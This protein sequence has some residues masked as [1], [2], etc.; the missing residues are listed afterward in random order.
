MGADIKAVSN[1]IACVT[2]QTDLTADAVESTD[3]RASA[4]LVAAGLIAKGETV[5]SK[6]EH[7][8]RGY[9]TLDKFLAAVGADIKRV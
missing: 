3:L 5:V 1:H 9:E 2:G 7:L 4:C 6:V 8:D